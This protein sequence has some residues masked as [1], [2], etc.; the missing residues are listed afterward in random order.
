MWY[1]PVPPP[2]SKLF[3][4]KQ[5]PA[6][7]IKY[8]F[9]PE[10]NTGQNKLSSSKKSLSSNDERFSNPSVTG[11][12]IPYGCGELD[13]VPLAPGISNTSENFE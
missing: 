5:K 12:S 4:R 7:R 11:T 8:A 6:K 13:A 3:K 9:K 10:R 1:S 2:K